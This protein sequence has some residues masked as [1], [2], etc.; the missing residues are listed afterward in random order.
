M[1]ETLPGGFLIMMLGT[2]FFPLGFK[3]RICI[4]TTKKIFSF[5]KAASKPNIRVRKM[6]GI[7][8]SHITLAAGAANTV[9][10]PFCLHLLSGPGRY[11]GWA[12]ETPLIFLAP[13]LTAS[14]L[15]YFLF[16]AEH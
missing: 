5:Y 9:R 1:A 13:D 11:D 15:I 12:G 14:R 10:R 7:M 16:F 4:L 6:V 8:F 2:S 3:F